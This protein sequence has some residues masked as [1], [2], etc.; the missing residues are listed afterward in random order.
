MLATIWPQR[1]HSARE[2]AF[3]TKDDETAPA[4]MA[5]NAS[6]LDGISR[7]SGQPTP[8]ANRM[9]RPMSKQASTPADTKPRTSSA[10]CS[11][12]LFIRLLL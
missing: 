1:I 8:V 4:L 5:A 10:R 6:E 2:S 12:T 9:G 7:G 3:N 11:P